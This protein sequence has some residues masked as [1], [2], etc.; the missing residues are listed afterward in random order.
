[1]FSC[2]GGTFANGLDEI[3]LETVEGRA[4]AELEIAWPG[5]YEVEVVYPEQSCSA[6]AVLSVGLE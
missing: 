4:T 3:E 6:T 2:P 5:T 1:V